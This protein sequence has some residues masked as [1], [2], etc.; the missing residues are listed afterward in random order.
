[1]K[2]NSLKHI[3][4]EFIPPFLFKFIKNSGN[5]GFF[6]NYKSWEEAS[7]DSMGYDSDIILDK[8]K[9]SLL[10]VKEGKAA[11]ARDA[12]IFEQVYYSF[13]LLAGLQKI[14]LEN[15]GNLN[16]LDFGGSLGTTYYQCRKFIP[17]IDNIQWSIV[18]QQNFVDCGKEYFEDN[19]LSFFYTIDEC[20]NS[21]KPDV[22]LLSGVIQ[23]LEN[24]YIF[25]DS[26]LKHNFQYILF[27][28]TAFVIKGLDR[29]TVQR[30]HPKIY[31]ASYPSWFLNQEKFKSFFLE[32]YDLV[33][34][35]DSQDTVN[36]PSVFK[37]FFYK[38]KLG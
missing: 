1:M 18:E 19:I 17:E 33:F 4:K 6:G 5:Y 37:G 12:V 24:P 11:Y 10:K 26:L 29:L 28:R 3:L 23:C 30:V 31:P 14:A 36:L 20:I 16:I 15:H 21:R 22:I 32:K 13:P 7:K 9:N 38:K 2:V 27:D 35:F 34:E 25:L 8:V